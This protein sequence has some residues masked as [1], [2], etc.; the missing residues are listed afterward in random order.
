MKWEVGS[1]VRGLW[2]EDG[3]RVEA[4]GGVILESEWTEG[5]GSGRRMVGGGWR[6]RVGGRMEKEGWH[7]DGGGGLKGVKDGEGCGVTEED[8][9]KIQVKLEGSKKGED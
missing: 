7:G 9:L 6:R 4:E 8:C 1:R 3:W 2:V 5:E